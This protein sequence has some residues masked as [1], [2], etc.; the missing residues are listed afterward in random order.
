M[1]R[2]EWN[3]AKLSAPFP[4][5]EIAGER[6]VLIEHHQGVCSYTEEQIRIRVRYGEVHVYGGKLCV[7]RMTREQLVIC[8][9]IDRVDL[10]RTGETHGR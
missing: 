9:M 7:A 10:I 6:R 5:V 1:G 8:G 2:K 4:L 3:P